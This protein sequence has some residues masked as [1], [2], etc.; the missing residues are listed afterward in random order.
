MVQHLERARPP[1]RNDPCPCG[2]GK[3]YKRC[4]L[5]HEAVPALDRR[6]EDVLAEIFAADEVGDREEAIRI[7][8]EARPVVHDQA[9][10]S[11]LV[12]RYLEL[13][14]DR[15]ES[16]LRA[17]WEQ[18][19]DRYSAAGLAQILCSQQRCD[20]ALTLLS[21]SQG[22]APP[23]YWR[24]L[25]TLRDECGDMPGAVSALE[26]YTRLTPDDTEAWLHLASM[27]ERIGQ[28]SRALL[29]LR[30]AADA[31]P[32]RILPRMLRLQILA[33]DGQWREVRDSAEALLEGQ[34]DDR[35]EDTHYELRDLLARAYFVLG[36]FAGARHLWHELLQEHPHDD[37]VRLQLATLELS[38]GRHRRALLALDHEIGDTGQPRAL[39][40]RLRCF[41]AL[42]EFEE[43]RLVAQQVEEHDPSAG[44]TT[45]CRAAEA[46]A[47]DDCVWAIQLLTTAPSEPYHD[48]YCHLRLI[49]LV[50]L[51][52]WR[53]VVPLLKGI[54]RPDGHVLTE[55]ALAALAAGKLD[56]AERLLAEVEDQQALAVHAL[57]ELLGPIRQARHAAEVRRQQQVDE[58]ERQRRALESRDLRRRVREL[59]RHNAALA[60]ALARSEAAFERLLEWVGV[61]GDGGVPADWEAQLRQIAQRAHKDAQVEELRQAESRLRG[62]LGDRVW[63]GLAEEV[64][65]ALREGEWLF[66]AVEGEDRDYGAALLE[67]ARGLERAFKEAIFV[68]ARQR[69]AKSPGPLDRLQDEAHDPSLGPFVGF[70]VHGGH[71][72]LGSMAAALDRMGDD[73]R[74][75]IAVTLLRHT[76]GLH[77]GDEHALA[78][79]RRAAERLGLAADARNQ[80][81]HAGAVSRDMVKNFRDLVLGTHGLLRAL[82]RG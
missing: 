43:A 14:P 57:R 71:L 20:E 5:V 1:G 4:C 33:Q 60:D 53:E 41:L 77:P 65:S 11:I 27:Q 73:R 68:P 42:E 25:S 76:L 67:Y 24:L 50:R 34:Y 23:E 6:F 75:G 22:E 28:N 49:C 2:S 63:D 9:L 74:Q 7:M 62:M 79:W 17:W 37:E 18:D 72:T 3:K 78:D 26:L 69:W 21:D 15:A 80:P 13:P 32:D 70:V 48:L 61:S 40:I 38:A 46:V 45:L 82:E 31:S 12:E 10:D 29:S 55:A 66:A 81:A 36:D 39:D 56:L 44:L 59:E 16:C 35:T 47:A 8:E 52:R 30:R 19:H 58:A 54:R 64:R 51:G